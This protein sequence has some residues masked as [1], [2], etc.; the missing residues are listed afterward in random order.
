MKERTRSLLAAAT[1]I[2]IILSG[3][4]PAKDSGEALLS[5]PSRPLSLFIASDPHY[6]SPQMTDYGEGFMDLIERGDGKVIHYTPE[7]V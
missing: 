3:C 4:T 5:G 6:L 1:A 2:L 7:I